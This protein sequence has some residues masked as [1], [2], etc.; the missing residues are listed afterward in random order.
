MYSIIASNPGDTSVLKKKDFE[1]SSIKPN[2]VL[3]K[4]HSIGVN[5]IDIYFREGLYPWPQEKDLVLGSEAAGEIEA[6]GSE[7]KNFQ[8]GDR[9]AYAQPNNAY[10]THRIIDENL[11]VSIPDN[12]SFDQAAASILKGLTVKY[13]VTDSFKLQAHHKVLFH[14]AAGGVGLIAGQW[15]SQIGCHLIGT[16]GS[17]EKCTKAKVYGY[18]E[19]INYSNQ[20]FLKEVQQLTQMEGVDVVYDSVG[21]DTMF[22]SFKCLKKHGTVVSFGQSSGMYKNLQMTDLMTGS[23]HLTRPTLFHFYAN[24]EWLVD[25]SILLFEMISQEKIKFN[26]ISEYSLEDVGQAHLDIENRRTTGSVILKT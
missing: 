20:N 9:V 23:L 5:F 22:D 3:V 1:I 14:A 4:N 25:A 13:L 19:M 15:I 11:I 6:V 12:V 8:V 26:E 18:D 24:R 16:A 21:Q 10:A 7:V 2:E 17:D